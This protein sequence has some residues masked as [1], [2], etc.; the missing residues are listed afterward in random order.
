MSSVHVTTKNY[1]ILY[2][3]HVF[4]TACRTR[5]DTKL[6]PNNH[7]K[8]QNERH[9]ISS[10]S[11]A[12][13]NNLF[14]KFS[15]PCENFEWRKK[16]FFLNS[17]TMSWINQTKSNTFHFVKLHIYFRSLRFTRYVCFFIDFFRVSLNLNNKKNQQKA[18]RIAAF[19]KSSEM[20][21]KSSVV[22]NRYHQFKRKFY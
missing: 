14:K 5:M 2:A 10:D 6:K 8:W 12:N 22:C 3:L 9:H 20:I 19:N 17:E 4:A 7:D 1:S 15:I 13:D 21:C 11:I 18:R 16:L